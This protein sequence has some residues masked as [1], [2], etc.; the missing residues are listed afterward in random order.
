MVSPS[1]W[2]CCICWPVVTGRAET[3]RPATATRGHDIMQ[4]LLKFVHVVDPAAGRNG[5]F[6]VLIEGGRLVRVEKIPPAGDARVVGLP[7]GFIVTPAM[8]DLPA[9]EGKAR[10][11]HKITRGAGTASA[12]AG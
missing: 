6:D 9:H 1:A 12:V 4:L 5:E 10:Q 2:P 7:R 11:Q 3:N 8:V